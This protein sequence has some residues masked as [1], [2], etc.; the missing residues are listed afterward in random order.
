MS[1]VCYKD[2]FKYLYTTLTA[3]FLT[4]GILYSTKTI[5]HKKDY[6]EKSVWWY[7]FMIFIL[8]ALLTPVF[9]KFSIFS[10]RYFWYASHILAYFLATFLSPGQWPY[11][12]AIGLLWETFECYYSCNFSLFKIRCGGIYDI[13]ANV[14]GIAV[15]MWLRSEIPVDVL[16]K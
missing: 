5:V 11:W 3:L 1:N 14:A 16:L 9:N 13:V 10:N 2:N 6:T 8:V 7:G 4:I 12:L 15:A